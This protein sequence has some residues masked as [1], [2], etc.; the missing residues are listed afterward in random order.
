MGTDLASHSEEVV[1][2]W[3]YRRADEGSRSPVPYGSLMA[4]SSEQL[5]ADDL[6][7]A[8]YKVRARRKRRVQTS[9]DCCLAGDCAAVL[10]CGSSITPRVPSC[11][12]RPVGGEP[13]SSRERSIS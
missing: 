5:H 3:V 2:L 10:P 1:A 4:A 13:H 6:F 12:E 8:A 9:V 11:G 7:G